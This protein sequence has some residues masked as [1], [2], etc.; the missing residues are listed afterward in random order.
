MALTTNANRNT[1]AL[2]VVT[3]SVSPEARNVI[4]EANRSNS[5][6]NYTNAQ[7]SLASG[8]LRTEQLQYNPSSGSFNYTRVIFKRN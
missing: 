5:S 4:S 6:V 8:E 1:T 2:A 7:G 3:N